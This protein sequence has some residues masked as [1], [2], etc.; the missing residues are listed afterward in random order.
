ML[1]PVAKAVAA[2]ALIFSAL[3]AAPALSAGNSVNERKCTGAKHLHGKPVAAAPAR[4]PA[5]ARGAMT[6]EHRKLDVQILSF[7]P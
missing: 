4:K 2:A 3:F 5:P 1:K 7:G 6:V